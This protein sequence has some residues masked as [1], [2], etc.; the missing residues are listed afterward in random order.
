VADVREE[1][2]AAMSDT[3][4]GF[5]LSSRKLAAVVLGDG[6]VRSEVFE[7]PKKEKDRGRIL[8]KFITELEE[9]FTE[10]T[11]LDGSLWVYVEH[12]LKGRGG[13]HATIVQAQVQG[14]VLG[15]SVL[16]GASGAYHVNVT[17]WKK[18]VVG[19]G[20]ADKDRVRGWLE[21]H[22]PDLAGLAGD[23]Q[24]LV[25]ASCVALYGRGVIERA[26]RLT[27]PVQLDP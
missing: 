18:D 5:D 2:G 23:D 17:T 15:T 4:V 27:N 8:A 11:A 13:V 14:L 24:D 22:H 26:G 6:L 12:P 19:H 1:V 7:A 16:F 3:I 20:G 9:F 10:L 21:V 25:D